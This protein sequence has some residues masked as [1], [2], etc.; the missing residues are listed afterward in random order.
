MKV[1]IGPLPRNGN[2]DWPLVGS[3]ELAP[4]FQILD[5][6]AWEKYPYAAKPDV[7]VAWSPEYAPVDASSLRGYTVAVYGDHHI[8]PFERVENMLAPF[9]LI[10]ADWRGVKRLRELGYRDVLYWRQFSFDPR[11]HFPGHLRTVD[12][13]FWG[14]PDGGKRDAALDRLK[15]IC[16]RNGWRWSIRGGTPYKRGEEAHAYRLARIVW[17]LSA[18]GELN[19]RAYEAAACGALSM[20][21][22]GNDELWQ[23]NAPL[24]PWQDATLEEQLR[25]WLDDEPARLAKVAEQRAWVEKESPRRHLE[26]LLKQIKQRMEERDGMG[27]GSR[28]NRQRAEG[29]GDRVRGGVGVQGDPGPLVEPPPENEQRPEV[30]ALVP[31]TARKVLDL[32][33]HTGG[34]PWRLKRDRP[35]IHV[36]GVD[37]DERVAPLAAPR[38]DAFYTFN[39][40]APEAVW[41]EQPWYAAGGYDCVILADVVEH[42]VEPRRLVEY[43]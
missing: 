7:T 23:A 13:A 17:N 5:F 26:W 38:M 4:E 3:E 6:P 2:D 11:L 28:G 15:A 27:A 20:L 42:V 34:V 31:P 1:A 8:V 24:V 43:V 14:R 37:I 9:N 10:A 41:R 18:R 12:V 16:Q 39:L 32:G 33:T 19:M 36:T 25:A 22:M 40:T 29:G 21:E 35:G 30:C